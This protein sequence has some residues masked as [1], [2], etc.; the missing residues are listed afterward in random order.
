MPYTER[1]SDL[2]HQRGVSMDD[3]QRKNRRGTGIANCLHVI[4]VMDYL[5]ETMAFEDISVLD[6]CKASG[7]SR[8]TFYRFFEDKFDAVNWIMH[9]I[10]RLGHNN[11]GRTMNWYDASV[12]SLSGFKLIKHLL[13]SASR[14]NGYISLRETSIRL[15][16]ANLTETLETHKGVQI[17]DELRYEIEFFA[18]AEIAAVHRWYEKADQLPVETFA[19]YIEQVVPRRLHDLLAM[20]ND[21]AKGQRLTMGRI[22]ALLQ[23]EA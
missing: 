9:E 16:M 22:A 4:S 15:R 3:E 18:H 8:S 2:I 19:G 17:D 7:L 1:G 11:T 10:S 14:P 21:P 6:I 12:V 20:P 23:E 5:C 13:D